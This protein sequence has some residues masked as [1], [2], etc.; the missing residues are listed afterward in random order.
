MKRNIR[1]LLALVLCLGLTLSMFGPASAAEGEIYLR[2]I[3]GGVAQVAFGAEHIAVLRCDGTVAATGNNDWGQ[4]DVS[5]WSR[6][7]KIWAAGNVTLG[8]TDAGDL[9]CTAGTLNGWKDIV[10]ADIAPIT[11][12]EMTV[13]AG[14]KADGTAVSAGINALVGK[15]HQ[16]IVRLCL[17]CAFH[18]VGMHGSDHIVLHILII[19]CFIFQIFNIKRIGQESYIKYQI[20]ICRNTMLK[21]ERKNGNHQTVVLFVLYKN[22]LQFFF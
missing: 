20:R 2:P 15:L 3:A 22:S 12:M 7:V 17:V 16:E 21:S 1:R 14:L 11:T 19:P 6:I 13:V 8:L 4:C 5:D 10:D 9:L 18:F